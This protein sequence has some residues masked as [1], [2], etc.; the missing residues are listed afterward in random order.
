MRRRMAEAAQVAWST[1]PYRFDRLSVRLRH[2]TSTSREVV[3]PSTLQAQYGPRPAHLNDR[4][5]SDEQRRLGVTALIAMGV[6]FLVVVGV[7][8][9]VVVLVLRARRRRPPPGGAGSWPPSQYPPPQYPPPPSPP[10]QCPP[11]QSPPPQYPPPQYPPPNY[12]PPQ[13]Y[14]PPNYPP[15]GGPAGRPGGWAPP[16]PPP[17]R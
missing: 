14:P 3:L 5:V 13:P 8:V 9:L 1:F 7:V 4:S 11:P 12:P 6:A 16:P 15:P 2:G 17:R 10:P